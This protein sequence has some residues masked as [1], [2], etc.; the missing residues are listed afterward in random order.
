VNTPPAAPKA[1]GADADAPKARPAPQAPAKPVA[2]AP[3]Q[4]VAQPVVVNTTTAPAPAPSDAKPSAPPVI[5]VT[6]PGQAQQAPATQP[7][8][9]VIR[10]VVI[11]KHTTKRHSSRSHRRHG[12]HRHGH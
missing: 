9:Q 2:Q 12:R 10:K 1:E 8:R 6:V 7:V 5:N 3:L 4:P 11:K